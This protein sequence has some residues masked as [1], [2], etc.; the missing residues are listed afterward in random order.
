MTTIALTGAT[1]FV[2][3]RVLTR[4]LA[5]GFDVRALTRQGLPPPRFHMRER[6][7]WING[8]LSDKASLLTLCTGADTLIHIAGVIKAKSEAD[9]ITG[10]VT[11]TANII[12][13]A[14]QAGIKRII[15]VSSITAREP[16]LSYYSKTK[17]AA[18]QVVAA[19]DTDWS[20]LR[21][22]AVYGPSDRETLSFFKAA[23]GF[24]L[25]ISNPQAKLSLIHVDDAAS[26]IVAACTPAMIGKTAELGDG[27]VLTQCA[28]AEAIAA[29]VG[30]RP[31]IV[32]LSRSLAWCAGMGS[33]LLAKAT[34][35][36]PMLTRKKVAELYHHDWSSV[37]RQLVEL[38]GWHPGID[39][40]SGLK[41]TVAW[42]QAQGWLKE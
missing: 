39:L 35:K 27:T 9:F 38:T 33:E 31:L 4:L 26:A 20:I 36:T 10:N 1:G 25:P 3:A 37:D 17:A 23:R 11:G 30:G 24:V 19:S 42:Y 40:A 16:Q 15:H 12:A 6:L 29:S 7:S 2:G 41:Q 13:A 22:T 14:K 5:G 8:S 28:L 21:L 32:P 18:E 34:N